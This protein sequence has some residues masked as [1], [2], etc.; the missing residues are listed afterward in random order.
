METPNTNAANVTEQLASE[1]AAFDRTTMHR[2]FAIAELREAFA[3]VEN[4]QN[5]KLPIS[6]AVSPERVALYVT[7]IE[8]MVGGPTKVEYFA[9]HARLANAG[10]YANI[11]A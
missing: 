9:D 5:W 6:A 8:F 11:G 10:Y 4:Q 3:V 1:M 7:A 2:G